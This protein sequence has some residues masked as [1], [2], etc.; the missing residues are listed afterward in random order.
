VDAETELMI[1][2]VAIA[3]SVYLAIVAEHLWD[4][5]AAVMIGIF[6]VTVL[7]EWLYE[8]YLAWYDRNN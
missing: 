6:L 8:T 2:T 5:E 4:E 7:R 3:G 1:D